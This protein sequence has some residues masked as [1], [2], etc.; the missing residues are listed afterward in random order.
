[1]VRD[2]QESNGTFSNFNFYYGMPGEDQRESFLFTERYYAAAYCLIPFVRHRDFL[3]GRYDDF[4]ERG[5]Q[6]LDKDGNRLQVTRYGLSVAAYVYALAGKRDKAEELL[7][8]IEKAYKTHEDN[9][10]CYKISN[11]DNW[12]NVR[13]TTFVALAYIELNDLVHA[14]PVVNY[15][16]ERKQEYDYKEDTHSLP[17][18]TEPIA[19]MA[20]AMH[21]EE[22]DLKISLANDQSFKQQLTILKSN[23]Q[24]P[25]TVE[26]PKGSQQ[27]ISTISGKGFCTVT[28]L[29]ER[30]VT[31]SQVVPIF[32]I[33]LRKRDDPKMQGA[34]YV[35]V[36]ATYK[37]QTGMKSV[38]VNV[39][40]EVEMPSG[41]IFMD[42]YDSGNHF[43]IKVR[44][45]LVI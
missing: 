34:K 25:Q 22:T 39:V 8:E 43:E 2:L 40:Y 32:D 4:I 19:N 27:V 21:V 3:D 38:L 30:I 26:M 17:I 1:M 6:Y 13:H 5:F 11:S 20:I 18:V 16:L 37:Q 7:R 12:C 14:E 10:R 41:Y 31:S 24:I 44:K 35:E 15:M 36:C 33:N 45:E 23:S 42:V 29:F 9:H 28:M